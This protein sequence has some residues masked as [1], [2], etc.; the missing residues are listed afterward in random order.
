MQRFPDHWD[1]LTRVNYL[2][3]KILLLSISYYMFD[4]SPVSDHA[5]DEMA[6]QLADLMQKC[7]RVE[8]STYWYVYYDYEGSTGFNLFYRLNQKDK[9]YLELQA[10]LFG[11][12]WL[13]QN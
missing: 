11:R 3:R 7:D 8:E 12:K 1:T 5:Y 13:K 2:Q 9:D 4:F 10:K 6:H